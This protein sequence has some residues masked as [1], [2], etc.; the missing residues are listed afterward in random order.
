MSRLEAMSRRGPI[1]TIHKIVRGV[2]VRKILLQKTEQHI[3]YSIDPATDT[4][5][6]RSVW[7]ARRGSLPKL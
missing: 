4:V 5:L 2:E 6:V 1:G 3:Y 7:G